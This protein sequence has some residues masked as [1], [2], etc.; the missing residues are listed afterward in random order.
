MILCESKDIAELYTLYS[1]KW[2]KDVPV[3]YWSCHYPNMKLGN[4]QYNEFLRRN[5]LSEELS[6]SFLTERVK[7]LCRFSFE[8]PD[9]FLWAFCRGECFPGKTRLLKRSKHS[10]AAAETLEPSTN[11]FTDRRSSQAIGVFKLL[12]S[13]LN[14]PASRTAPRTPSLQFLAWGAGFLGLLE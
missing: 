9:F 4:N 14:H 3:H 13:T 10:V 5:D 2:V 11:I 12:L 6:C 1:W 8:F 7:C